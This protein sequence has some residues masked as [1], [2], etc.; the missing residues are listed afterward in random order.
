MTATATAV[1]RRIQAGAPE[2][3][4]LLDRS[5]RM[6]GDVD[7][8]VAAIV[9]DVR[10]RRDA[11]VAEYTRRF[12]GREPGPRGYELPAARWDELAAR[13][14][15]PVTRGARAG[16]LADR[17]F[18]A[19]ARCRARST[20]TSRR[21]ACASSCGSGRSRAPG[22]MSRAGPRGTRRAC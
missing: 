6:A 9:E 5:T 2:G 12:D 14:A 16:G 19:R 11:A 8:Q 10:R 18:H 4:A 20:S 7:A 21:A 3:A 13:V 17:A 15:A 22:S 1:L